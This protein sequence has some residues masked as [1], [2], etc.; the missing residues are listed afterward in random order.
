MRGLAAVDDDNMVERDP[1][2]VFGVGVGVF[3]ICFFGVLYWCICMHAFWYTQRF[4]ATCLC[5]V[6]CYGSILIFLVY[7]DREDQ[8]Y[9][10][11]Q[12]THESAQ[13]RYKYVV[14]ISLCCAAVCGGWHYNEQHGDEQIVALPAEYGLDNK[15]EI[16]QRTSL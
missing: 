14:G 2:R 12:E 11:G 6:I 4:L 15:L 3:L 16:I 9:D 10:P 5:A 8:Y 1:H 7:G 13:W